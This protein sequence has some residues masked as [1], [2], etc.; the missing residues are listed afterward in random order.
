MSTK[1]RVTVA[2]YVKQQIALNDKSQREIAEQAGFEKPNV[3]SMIKTGNTKLPIARV[4]PLAKA[5][6]VDP[7]YLLRLVLSE[8]LPDTYQAVESLIGQSLVS[9]GELEIV[10]AMRKAAGVNALE[11]LSD[12]HLKQVTNLVR[13]IAAE[14]RSRA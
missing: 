13:R 8:Y 4:G 12:K 5:L 11:G 7:A 1:K 3:L 10:K 9:K 14:H 6:G 2:E